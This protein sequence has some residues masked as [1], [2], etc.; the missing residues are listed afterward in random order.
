LD[1]YDKFPAWRFLRPTAAKKNG[2]KRSPLRSIDP[3]RF[4]PV[5]AY[6]NRPDAAKTKEN[7][8]AEEDDGLPPW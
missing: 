3:R 7:A 4:E 8:A 1:A 6:N 5:P 2:L